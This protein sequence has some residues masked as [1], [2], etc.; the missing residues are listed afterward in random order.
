MKF[1]KKNRIS[2]NLGSFVRFS[3]S[4]KL[5]GTYARVGGCCTC[6]QTFEILIEYVPSLTTFWISLTW[7]NS[8]PWN[9]TWGYVRLG[10]IKPGLHSS[11]V[12]LTCVQLFEI[13]IDHVLCFLWLDLCPSL[14]IPLVVVYRLEKLNRAYTRV[15]M[16]ELAS[17]PPRFS[18]AASSAEQQFIECL[19]LGTRN[20][21]TSVTQLP[22]IALHLHPELDAWPDLLPRPALTLFTPLPSHT[23]THPLCNIRT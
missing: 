14:G 18:S 11:W 7:I 1:G 19:T 5:N 15:E 16:V 23:H 4:E 3:R 12:G 22:F 21:S 20:V 2:W 10:E 9:S 13:L 17:E 8:K 6:V